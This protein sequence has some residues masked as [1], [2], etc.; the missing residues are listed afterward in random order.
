MIQIAPPEEYTGNE[1]SIF[2]AGGISDCE[3]WQDRLVER[4][5]ESN[6]TV[7]NPRQVAYP[8]DD[9]HAA[10]NQI[11]WEFRH[12]QRATSHLFWFPPQTLCPM[13]LFELGR[14][15]GSKGPLFVGVDPKYGRKLDVEIQL[16]LV[17]PDVEIVH[18]LKALADKVLDWEKTL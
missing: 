4:L 18:Q 16:R 7:L 8:A 12:L 17:R 6:L 11:R 5:A 14:W 2:L 15:T 9:A 3:P 1:P 10:E 13:A